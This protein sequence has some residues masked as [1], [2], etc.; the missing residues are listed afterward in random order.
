[1]IVPADRIVMAE[2]PSGSYVAMQKLLEE[3]SGVP[4]LSRARYARL[5]LELVR[6]ISRWNEADARAAE[7]DRTSRGI[8]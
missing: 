2:R 3:A 5:R 8:A 1:M 6:R 7:E 4:A